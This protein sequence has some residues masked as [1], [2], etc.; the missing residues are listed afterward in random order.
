MRLLLLS[1]LLLMLPVSVIRA[2]G[3]EESDN[4]PQCPDGFPDRP[5]LTRHLEQGAIITGVYKFDDL[6]DH[7]EHLFTA[8]FNR[9]DGQGRPATT[10]T[11]VNREPGQPAL[12]RISGPDAN[13]CAGCHQQP[14]PGGSGDFIANVF[15]L[16]EAADPVLNTTD[17]AFSNL[18]NTPGLFGA[19]P[20]EML[21]R[22]MTAELHAIRDA[23]VAQAAA[24]DQTVIVPLI[25]KGISFGTLT[26][27]ADGTVNAS[28]VAGVDSDLIIKPFHQS[29]VVVS[30]REFTVNSMNQHHG[31]QAEERF[32]VNPALLAADYDEDGVERELTIG[33]ITAAVIWQAAL[34]IPVQVLPEDPALLAAVQHGESLF[35]QIGC[36]SCHVPALP[37]KSRFFIEPNPYNPP[38]TWA[39]IGQPF[40]FDMTEAGEYPRLERVD[41][42]AVVR[43]YTD[44]KRHNLC[45]PA[46][47]PDAI[48]YFCNEQLA[49]GRPD[50]QGRPGAEFFITRRL[51]D[52]GSSAP[53]GHRGDLT[54]I[55]EAILMHG[56]EARIS[57]DAFTNLEFSDQQA[58]VD[59]LR[60]LQ[61]VPAELPAAH[62]EQASGP[63][64]FSSLILFGVIGGVALSRHKFKGMS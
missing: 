27:Q 36:A 64:T 10:G 28:N 49:Q 35:T 43:A 62:P 7:G 16:A 47:Q 2:Q 24:T 52:V 11:G 14:R 29:G 15:V 32:D 40:V 41:N 58:L 59:F 57:R 61:V 55:T 54:T 42:G 9:C 22:E 53:Y 18:R 23:A 44:L 63:A 37:L 19:G 31:M 4:T 38:G 33:D 3:Y 51:W 39:D 13:S 56:G 6:F 20:I 8:R 30:I 34:G 48:R 46:D 1:V 12:S 17:A 26:V 5:A 60:T 45:D 21:A 25:V 50:S